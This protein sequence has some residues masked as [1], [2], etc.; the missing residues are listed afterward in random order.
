MLGGADDARASAERRVASA[1]KRA[2][3]AEARAESAERAAAT[4]DARAAASALL[5][6]P[7]RCSLA[8]SLASADAG[9]EG[10]DE[11]E[12]RASLG[13]GAKGATSLDQ[14]RARTPPPTLSPSAERLS[15]VEARLLRMRARSDAAGGGAR[16]PTRRPSV[17]QSAQANGGPSSA[18]ASP[19]LSARLAPASPAP[20]STSLALAEEKLNRMR[21]RSQTAAVTPPAAPAVLI[22]ANGNAAS[23]SLGEWRKR[24]PEALSMNAAEDKLRQIRERQ[25]ARAARAAA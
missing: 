9:A 6:P 7:T 2:E 18:P 8:G 5:L 11:A 23:D 14:M 20:L 1:M 22:P 3:E 24:E 25:A 21:V 4:A 13:V 15:E 10:S 12:Q 16:T 17:G 19:A